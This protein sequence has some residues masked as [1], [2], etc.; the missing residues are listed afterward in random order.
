VQ[1]VRPWSDPQITTLTT[2]SEQTVQT[3]DKELLQPAESRAEKPRVRFDDDDDYTGNHHVYE[4]YKAGLPPLRPYFRELWARRQFAFQLSKTKLRAKNYNTVLGQLWMVLTPVLMACVYFV[5]VMVIRGGS[6]GVDFFA[7][8]LAALFVFGLFSNA[9]QQASRSIVGGGKLVLNTAFP[10]VL[11]PMSAVVGSFRRFLPTIPIYIPVH[12][13]VGAPVGWE[14][15]LTIPLAFLI[16][17]LATGVSCFVAAAQVY[18]RDLTSFLPHVLRIWTYS[19]PI[20][21]TADQAIERG[22][23]PLLWVNPM[24]PLIRAWSAV[25]DDGRL[26]SL[27]V[28]GAGA[29]WAVFLFFAGV[30]FFMTRERELAVRL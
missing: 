17:V 14:L 19:S 18:F 7:H 21:Y 10:R 29:A 22:L 23:G 24:A 5:L 11:L 28:V 20:I 26:P 6:R 27:E 4:P 3:T 1:D 8:L 2:V 12:L 15:L 25:I 13:A 30:I 9:V 16:M